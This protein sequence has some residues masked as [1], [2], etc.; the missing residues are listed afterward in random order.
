MALS[1]VLRDRRVTSA[2]IGASSPEQVI[3]NSKCVENSIF[4][5]D[6]EQAVDYLLSQINLPKSLWAGE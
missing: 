3:E 2:L 4:S 5:D 6:E 1:W